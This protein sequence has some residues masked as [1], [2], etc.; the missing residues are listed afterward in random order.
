[1]PVEQRIK[2]SRLIE[3][4]HKNREYSEILGLENVSRFHGQEMIERT[5][6][7]KE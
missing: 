3:R 1:M 2:I 6:E 7:K 4:M 5:G